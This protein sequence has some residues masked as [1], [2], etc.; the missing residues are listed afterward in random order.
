MLVYEAML[1]HILVGCQMFDGK[2]MAPHPT[3][4]I[5]SSINILEIRRRQTNGLI[6]HASICRRRVSQPQN[7]RLQLA[8]KLQHV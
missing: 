7:L 5:T 3:F 2:E 1:S 8:C 4:R 6:L